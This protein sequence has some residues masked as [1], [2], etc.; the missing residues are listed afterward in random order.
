MLLGALEAGGTKFICAIG[1]QE[2]EILEKQSF[3]TLKPEETMNNVLEFFKGKEVA[4]M[5][6]GSFGPVGVNKWSSDYGYILETPKPYW[7]RYNLVEVIKKNITENIVFDTDVNGAAL[8][9]SMW[10]A[11]K[12]LSSC[13]YLTIGTGVGGG[14]V[15]N[16]NLIHGLLHPE[17]GHIMLRRHPEDHYEGKC[18]FHKDCLEGL[19]AGPSIEARFGGKAHLIP[20]DHPI[21]DYVSYYIAQALVNYT[22]ILSPEKLILGGGVMK[23][24]HLFP[25]I[26][27]NF[28]EIMNGYILKPELAEGIA[29]Y[30]VYPGL[31]DFAGTYGALALAIKSIQL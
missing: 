9:E 8:A 29:D 17:M 14:A 15:A 22:Y 5:G 28:I 12:G 25:K 13:L 1:T 11:A 23:Q 21:W 4:G 6:I 18:P 2:G 24:K 19:A 20:E 27:K 16:G 26:H 3:P 7:T 30:I 10:G 31:G